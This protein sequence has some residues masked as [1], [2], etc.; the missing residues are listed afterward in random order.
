[1]SASATSAVTWSVCAPVSMTKPEVSVVELLLV[2]VDEDA[3]PEVEVLGSP[4]VPLTWATRP[5]TGARSSVCSRAVRASS[6]PIS[7]LSTCA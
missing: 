4:T 5:A 1:M 7:A 6:T 2:P 3:E